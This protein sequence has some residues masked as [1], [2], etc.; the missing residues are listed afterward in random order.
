ME[1]VSCVDEDRRKIILIGDSITQQS[2][3]VENGG[4]G[5]WISDWYNRAADVINRGYSGYNS[6]WIAQMLPK[7]IPK[8]NYIIATVFLG[9]NDAVGKGE[10][11]HVPV[12]EYKQNLMD[13]KTHLRSL[14]PD[15]VII[16]VT[17]PT[18]DPILWPSRSPGRVKDYVE[19]VHEVYVSSIATDAKE[20]TKLAVLN[21]DHLTVDD[22]R[23][24]LHLNKD[25]NKKVF[26]AFAEL[27]RSQFNELAPVDDLTVKPK[28]S[29]HY[30]QCST[31]L[32]LSGEAVEDLIKE[33]A[34]R[35]CD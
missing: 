26:S 11:Q 22:L 2:F 7:L 6:R 23:D 12:D 19:A 33:I 8:G 29:L 4:F 28:L 30:P 15:V 10:T 1:S 5:S 17:P 34:A 27:M 32:D 24:G 20:R 13:I 21:L 3:S 31:F 16:F 25:G 9:A 14:S 18:V 35:E